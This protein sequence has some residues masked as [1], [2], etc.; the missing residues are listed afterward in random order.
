MNCKDVQRQIDL[1]L[2]KD[3]V[4]VGEAVKAHFETC[5]GCRNYYRRA[6]HLGNLLG[7]QKFEV[8]PGELDDL[9]FEKIAASGRPEKKTGFLQSIF[10]IR[11][12]WVPVAAAAIFIIFALFPGRVNH[13]TEIKLI[14]W[15]PSYSTYVPEGLDSTVFSSFENI[16]DDLE[17]MEEV[18]L[19][20]SDVDNLIESLTEEE[21]DILYERLNSKSGSA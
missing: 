8:L 10:S 17:I 14:D 11:W 2:K 9:T 20:D 19:Y 15:S 13:N 3:S 6:V 1:E 16:G 21:L 7:R 5:P 4:D 12:V 18:L